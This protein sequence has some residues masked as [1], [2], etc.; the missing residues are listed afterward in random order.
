MCRG[1]HCAPAKYDFKLRA[2][3][4]RPYKIYCLRKFYTYILSCQFS[5]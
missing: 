4:V 3:T 2:N 1:A 5:V